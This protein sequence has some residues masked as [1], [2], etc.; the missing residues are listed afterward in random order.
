MTAVCV[1]EVGITA[2]GVTAVRNYLKGMVHVNTMLVP[3]YVFNDAPAGRSR[4]I[5]IYGLAIRPISFIVKI[6]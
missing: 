6:C 4:G 1:T 5:K 3:I 2:V